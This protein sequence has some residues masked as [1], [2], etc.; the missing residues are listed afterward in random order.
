[1][2][3]LFDRFNI[4]PKK[5][6]LIDCF[7]ALLSALLLGV[8]LTRFEVFAGMPKNILYL[9]SAIPCLF[10]LY[11]FIAY[12]FAQ[13]NYTIHLKIIATANALYCCLTLGLV[14]YFYNQLSLLALMYFC[15]EIIIIITLAIIEVKTAIK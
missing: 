13:Q 6:L 7:G 2:P 8:V 5:L 9:L 12:R 15:S 14:F 10:A 4:A 1:M 11:T 3:T